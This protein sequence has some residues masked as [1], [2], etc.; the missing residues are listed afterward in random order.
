MKDGSGGGGGRL[1]PAFWFAASA[2]A[3]VV[4]SLC[5]LGVS[6]TTRR[7]PRQKNSTALPSAACLA[8]LS[9]SH[10]SPQL[11]RQIS[12]ARRRERRCWI[13]QSTC[14]TGWTRCKAPS[15]SARGRWRSA[16]FTHT[17]PG[18]GCPHRMQIQG[19]IS[20]E[21]RIKHSLLSPRPPNAPLLIRQVEATR[22]HQ[23]G[24]LAHKKHPPPRT[25][26]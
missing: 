15:T 8:L 1:T 21:S 13:A 26:R 25:L 12:P 19:T 5:V 4:C 16:G 9:R 7:T 18:A 20:R 17:H 22:K 14:S 23:Q 2:V 3:G 6:L 11:I 24:Y 10:V